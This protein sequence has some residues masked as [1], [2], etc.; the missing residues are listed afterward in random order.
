ML[1]EFDGIDK[2]L[3]AFSAKEG[4][5]APFRGSVDDVYGGAE[6]EFQ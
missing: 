6:N 2:N 4:T 5:C 1:P 3:I